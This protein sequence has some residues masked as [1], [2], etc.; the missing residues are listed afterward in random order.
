MLKSNLSVI[1]RE[2]RPQTR[3]PKCLNDHLGA[4]VSKAEEEECLVSIAV[5]QIH[6]KNVNIDVISIS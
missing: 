5:A 1:S 2:K 3:P 4:F 6:F